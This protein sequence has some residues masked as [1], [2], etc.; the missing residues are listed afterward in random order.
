MHVEADFYYYY[1]FITNSMFYSKAM[2][3][4]ILVLLKATVAKAPDS[5]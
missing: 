1:S 4:I 5:P 3:A 2:G